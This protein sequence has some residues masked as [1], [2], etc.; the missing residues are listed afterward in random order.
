MTADKKHITFSHALQ[1]HILSF[2]D[3]KKR[4]AEDNVTLGLVFMILREHNMLQLKFKCILWQYFQFLT[5]LYITVSSY[6]LSS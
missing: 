4:S 3:R 1:N 5:F 6:I 2:M